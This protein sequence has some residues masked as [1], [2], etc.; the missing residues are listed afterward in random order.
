MPISVTA[1]IND[2][3]PDAAALPQ[4]NDGTGRPTAT[5]KEA[6]GQELGDNHEDE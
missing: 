1:T 5:T 3:P 6:Q 4:A 2:A